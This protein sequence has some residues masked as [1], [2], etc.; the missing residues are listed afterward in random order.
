MIP[1]TNHYWGGLRW[2]HSASDKYTCPNWMSAAL[3]AGGIGPHDN[4]DKTEYMCF[5]QNKNQRGDIST[6]TDGSLKLADK[7]TSLRSSVSSTESNINTRLAKACSA[8]DSLSVIWKS[9]KHNKQNSF[10]FPNGSFVYT[11]IWLHCMNT[12]KR[13]DGNCT[14]MLRAVLNKSRK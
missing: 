4:A 6:L 11:T 12:E 13:L 10:F 14:R 8:I 7:F 3:S 1:R 9:V 2:W 5:N